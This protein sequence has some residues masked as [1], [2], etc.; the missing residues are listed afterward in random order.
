MRFV[1]IPP[2]LC[3]FTAF[4]ITERRRRERELRESERM[5][6]SVFGSLRSGI[7]VRAEDGTMLRANQALLEMFGYTEE[8][9]IGRP[10]T[11]FYP[12]GM[13]AELEAVHR[14]VADEGTELSGEFPAL[15]RDGTPM[16]IRLQARP[17]RTDDG[18][19]V[20][21]VVVDD[22]TEARRQE[23][24]LVHSERMAAVGVLAG[25]VAHHF[26]NLNCGILGLLELTLQ[27]A[28]LPA[29]SRK[30]IERVTETVRRASGLT[31]K[32]LHFAGRSR[33]SA[34]RVPTE[35]NRIVAD[36]VDLLRSSF[37]TDRIEIE[38][39]YS[40]APGVNLDAQ[41][42]GHILMCFLMN[43]RDAVSASETRRITVR[44]GAEEGAAFVS[45]EDSGPGV[46]EAV[47]DKIFLPFFST[48]GEHAE[49]GSPAKAI[50]GSGLG[51]SMAHA[52]AESHGGRIDVRNASA[53]GAIFTLRLPL[54]VPGAERPADG[55]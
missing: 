26:N 29:K 34:D 52:L 49:E 33:P 40:E 7:S 30:R 48:K 45:V 5:L 17:M 25:G 44:A 12:D 35:L 14:R 11:L 19:T 6:F 41:V 24:V 42:I 22:M 21:V 2:D 20:V 32:L 27:D 16:L 13:R 1:P 43:A 46:D 9:V 36:T 15:K 4:D 18:R 3:L 51:L 47:L 39:E 28:G 38:E 55:V 54:P 8:E 53:G 37:A 31:E 50:S 23:Q 10:F